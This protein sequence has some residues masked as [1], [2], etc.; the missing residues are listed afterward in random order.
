MRH[1]FFSTIVLSCLAIAQNAAPDGAAI[2]KQRCA[3]CHDASDVTRAPGPA[4]LRQMSPENIVRSLES[5]LMKQQGTAMPAAEKRIVAEFLT[6]K[7]IGQSNQAPKVG[8]CAE[9]KVP[10]TTN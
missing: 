2:Y 10:F 8:V 9:T 3:T 1:L 5:G 4:A 7:V 6:G